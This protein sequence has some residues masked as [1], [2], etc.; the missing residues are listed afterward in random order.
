MM[1]VV[2]TRGQTGGAGRR[3]GRYRSPMLIFVSYARKDKELVDELLDHLRPLAA[4]R[5]AQVWLDEAIEGGDAW[6]ARIRA[7]LAEACLVVA[8]VTP[9]FLQSPW[10]REES[11]YAREAGT[12][13]LPVHVSRFSARNNLFKDL[14]F[15]PDLSRAVIEWGDTRWQR[16]TAWAMVVDAVHELLDRVEAERAAAEARVEAAERVRAG[17]AAAAAWAEAAEAERAAKAAAAEAAERE[18]PT[19]EARKRSGATP[20]GAWR[21]PNAALVPRL[22][23]ILPGTEVDGKP[24]TFWMG[25][26]EGVG[27]DNER[28]RRLV[29]LTQAYSIGEAPVTQAQWR[30]V[31]EAAKAAPWASSEAGTG[32]LHPAPSFYGAGP[33]AARRPV[34]Q[35][36][37]HDAVVWCNALSRL[38]GRAPAYRRDGDAWGRNPGSGGFRLPTEAEWEHACRAG[39]TTLW[40]FGDDETR[41]GEFAWFGG[42][43]TG[44]THPVGAKKPNPWG[45]HDVHGNVW[46]WCEDGWSNPDDARVTVDPQVNPRGDA[47]VFR[48]G[49]CWVSA[50]WCRSAYRFHWPP[51]DRARYL[52]LR[53]ALSPPPSEAGD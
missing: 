6:E 18:R 45:L 28:P 44:S 26:P 25:S 4:E 33:D 29:T 35:V 48:G 22:I 37:W 49:C 47:R 8:C 42:G 34:E 20:A 52:G 50:D 46:E 15:V 3:T 40:S 14:Q 38:A 9:R 5:G 39:T 24:G 21:G 7:K 13:I 41:L 32:E 10:C 31:V 30:A 2:A 36:S 11:K 16:D 12:V 19:A 51:G 53:V 23:T 1:G 43:K 27:L 17:K